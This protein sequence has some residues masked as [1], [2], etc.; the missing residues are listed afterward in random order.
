MTFY[1][2]K[3]DSQLYRDITFCR[4]IF[5][6]IIQHQTQEQKERL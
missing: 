2:Q 4:N 1:I 3:V 6:D 5:L